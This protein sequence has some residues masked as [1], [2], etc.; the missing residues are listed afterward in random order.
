M[1]T[2][3]II[4]LGTMGHNL[5]LSLLDGGLHVVAHSYSPDEMDRARRLTD[6]AQ[7]E[8]SLENFV[9]ALPSPRR[10]LL[11]VTAGEPVDKVLADLTFRLH[12][13]DIVIDGGNSHF[14]DTRRRSASL[15][16]A[17]LRYVG[18]G[19]SGG[20]AGARHGAAL[21]PGGDASALGEC[22]DIFRAL[23]AWYGDDPCYAPVGPDGAG[24]FVKMV[25]NGIEYGIMQLIAELFFI[26]RQNGLDLADC[27]NIFASLNSGQAASYLLEIT[28]DI[29][30]QKDSLS[31]D[32]IIDRI[33]DVAGQKGTG[34]WTVDAS[35]DLG[36][37]VP[38]IEAAL[39]ARNLS[40]GNRQ[41]PI[42]ASAV[43]ASDPGGLADGFETLAIAAYAQGFDLLSAASDHFDWQLKL[44]DIARL[45]RGGCIIRAAILDDMAIELGK[46]VSL[47]AGDLA[48]RIRLDAANRIGVA[49]LEAGVP[50]PATL[51]SIAWLQTLRAERLP[52][53]MI[54][55]QRDY[56]GRHGFK[57]TDV[58][59]IHHHDW[60][61]T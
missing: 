50:A 27:A 6:K 31:E 37:P 42:T 32:A 10:I 26:L 18:C 11:M 15:G 39:S 5:M 43:S 22:D 23:T 61:A 24:H 20:E 29:L 17:N 53:A 13:G 46:N 59:G 12:A 25:H 33:S 52:T 1:S 9:A 7:F 60:D 49:A 41:L 44:P 38:T 47:L 36:V 58:E 28:A 2:I 55:A 14:N 34:R 45:W 51:A 48:A 35:L 19:I 16:E 56:F 21:M 54:Q 30:R 8:D 4:G 40:A 57:R 3:G